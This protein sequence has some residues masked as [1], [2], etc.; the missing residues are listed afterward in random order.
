[1]RVIIWGCGDYGRKILPNLIEQG[2]KEI[3]LPHTEQ[4]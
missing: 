1:M 3:Y 2:D 4:Q